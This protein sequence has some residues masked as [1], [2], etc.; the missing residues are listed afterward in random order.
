MLQPAFREWRRSRG[1]KE[2]IRGVPVY[3]LT[4]TAVAFPDAQTIVNG[5]TQLVRTAL[6]GR[7]AKCSAALRDAI[8]ALDFSLTTLAVTEGV[9]QTLLESPLQAGADSAKLV[10]AT[11]DGHQ[12]GDSFRF[13]R[14]FHFGNNGGAE[15]FRQAMEDALAAAVKQRNTRKSIRQ[16]LESV[17]VTAGAQQVEM[18]LVLPKNQA[19]EKTLETLSR[20]F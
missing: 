3:L 20:W 13:A 9:P 1:G 19:Q 11:T 16:V 18:I 7:P 15:E 8:P 4:T 12:F 2:T 5:E 14:T 10:V 6:S 17:Q